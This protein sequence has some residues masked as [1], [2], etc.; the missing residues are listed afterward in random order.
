MFEKVIEKFIVINEMK[1]QKT[2]EIYIMVL[3]ENLLI[4][5]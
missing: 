2:V 1:I 4:S 5:R 3:L